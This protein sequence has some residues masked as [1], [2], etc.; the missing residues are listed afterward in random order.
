MKTQIFAIFLILTIKFYSNADDCGVFNTDFNDINENE[1]KL[2]ER[3]ESFPWYVKLN[4][5]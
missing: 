1:L 5:I 3:N 4:V 2:L